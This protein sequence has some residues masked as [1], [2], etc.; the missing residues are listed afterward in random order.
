MNE[1]FKKTN[2]KQ[3]KRCLL[4]ITKPKII[5]NKKNNEI[6][7]IENNK[8]KI[9]HINKLKEI[10]SLL[11]Q[12]E[13]IETENNSLSLEIIKL[14]DKQNDI[15]VK[16]NKINDE[17]T[18]EKNELNE[19]KNINKTENEKYLKLLHLRIQ[20]QLTNSLNSIIYPNNVTNINN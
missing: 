8:Y 5:H 19:L 11:K 12:L 17:Y 9:I 18:K 1:R 3:G 13:H 6:S 2:Y 10:D 14:K 16:Y 4:P 7:S 20:Q 15:L